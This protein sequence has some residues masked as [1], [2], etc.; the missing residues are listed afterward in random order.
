MH[1]SLL[2]LGLGQLAGGDLHGALQ[3]KW[4]YGIGAA[5]DFVVEDQP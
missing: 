4:D 2:D 1:K 3:V 5:E